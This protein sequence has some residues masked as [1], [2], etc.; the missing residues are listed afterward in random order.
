M[1]EQSALVRGLTPFHAG[2]LVVGTVIGTGIFLKAGIMSQTVGAA[3]WMLLAWAAAG[4][5]SFLG[6]LVYAEVGSLFPR[7]GGEYVYMREAYGDLIGFLYGWMRFWIASPGSIAAFAVGGATFLGAANIPGVSTVPHSSRRRAHPFLYGAELPERPFRRTDSV[8][9]HL[10]KGLDHHRAHVC[11][12]Y[13]EPH[14]ELES[15]SSPHRGRDLARF[16]RLRN[17]GSGCTLGLRWLEQYAHGGGRN[18]E[19]AKVYSAIAHYRGGRRDAHL[20]PRQHLLRVRP[21]VYGAPQCQLQ[22]SSGRVAR[23]NESGVD[24]SRDLRNGSS[25]D[26]FFH[27]GHGRTQRL[28]PHE[29]P[30]PVCHG[31][32]K[33]DAKVPGGRSSQDPRSS[34][35]RS[36]PGRVGGCPC[37]LGD[38][39]SDHG[40]RRLRGMGF[41]CTGL[42]F[43]RYFSF[44]DS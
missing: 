5:L 29:R 43:T 39:R 11:H 38:L 41:L 17:R 13:I 35:I 8:L 40:L 37:S 6:A 16:C 3:H 20:C 10:I 26:R 2:A 9:R 19:P 36:Y 27:L 44:Q 24:L 33:H 31:C 21:S 7:A 22:A 25:F 1:G 12:L 15:F 28:G 18:S 30:H 14:G 4:I 34:A 42:H 32:R 23:S